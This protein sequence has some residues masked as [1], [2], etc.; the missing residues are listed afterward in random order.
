MSGSHGRRERRLAAKNGGREGGETATSKLHAWVRREL[1]LLI[2]NKGPG[3]VG[4][5]VT[6]VWE[7]REGGCRSCARIGKP[8]QLTMLTRQ[9]EVEK[10]VLFTLV[11]LCEECAGDADKMRALG[12]RV[13][14]VADPAPPPEAEPGPHTSCGACN[15]SGC[16]RCMDLPPNN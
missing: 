10:T 11:H 3:W 4:K 15:G 16:D 9:Q 6:P 13:F 12:D 1:S 14:G 7:E 5:T 8:C 2:A